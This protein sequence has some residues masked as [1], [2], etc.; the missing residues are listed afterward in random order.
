[1]LLLKNKF[2]VKKRLF[3]MPP[4]INASKWRPLRT[5]N[6][7]IDLKKKYRF[8]YTIIK[9]TMRS[10]EL[11]EVQL[12]P[13]FTSFLRGTQSINVVQSFKDIFAQ[14]IS[15]SHLDFTHEDWNVSRVT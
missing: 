6:L 10:G 13:L 7:I 9:S 4:R 12:P 2:L 5:T 3:C 1:M 15:D 11:Y 14:E 8:P